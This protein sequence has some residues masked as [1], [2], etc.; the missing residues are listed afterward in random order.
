MS[1]NQ[2]YNS[3]DNLKIDRV[4]SHFGVTDNVIQEINDILTL[5]NID[6]ILSKIEWFKENWKKTYENY[7]D[8]IE[9]KEKILDYIFSNLSKLLNELNVER[10]YNNTSYLLE[11]NISKDW[12]I[13]KMKNF[14]TIKWIDLNFNKINWVSCNE[15]VTWL[16][17]L[18]IEIIWNDSDI[19]YTF[20][21]NSNDIHG[22][23]YINIWNKKYSFDSIVSGFRFEELP[24]WEI[25]AKRKNKPTFY[26]NQDAYQESFIK[27]MDNKDTIVY[28]YLWKKLK[29]LKKAGLLM[30]AYKN[31][32]VKYINL[33]WFKRLTKN[34][35][36]L[37]SVK[38]VWLVP[39]VYNLDSIKEF[40]ISK[41]KVDD[42][43]D[44]SIILSQIHQDR[45]L[46]FFNLLVI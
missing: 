4:L 1:I 9:N 17:N 13:N 15:W 43:E 8:T 31:Q 10:V 18:L 5:E 16:Y 26:D 11:E 2:I 20:Q 7:W 29:I 23:L 19:K 14:L 25:K 35:S 22:L 21:I 44:I 30:I 39:E 27:W 36:K 45:L 37:S 42:R 46:K 3:E 41:V 40:I 32:P 33:H 6:S 38:Y 28:D 12:N 24:K 34:L